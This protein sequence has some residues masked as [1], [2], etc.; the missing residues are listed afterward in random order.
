MSILED[1]EKRCNEQPPK[2]ILYEPFDPV[3]R[4]R[5]IYVEAD[6][7]KFIMGPWLSDRDEQLSIDMQIDLDR[8]VSGEA[9]TVALQAKA[10]SKVANANLKR[11]FRETEVWEFRIRG[12]NP[13]QRVFGR[14]AELNRFIALFRDD[15]PGIDYHQESLRVYSDWERLLPRAAFKEGRKANDYVSEPVVSV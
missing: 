5:K 12:S 9:I 2:L 1:I 7:H 8:F 13:Q 14:F 4:K 6:L 15:R 10:K 11:L 3:P